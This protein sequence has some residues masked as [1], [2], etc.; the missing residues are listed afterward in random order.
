MEQDFSRR[1]QSVK[2]SRCAFTFALLA[3]F[4]SVLPVFAKTHRVPN[5]DP[6]AKL[7]IPD[8]WNVQ[9]VGESLQATTT[10]GGEHVM[11]VP[12]EGTK[13][14]ESLGEAI[15][16]VR[17]SGG[18]IIKADS[19]KQET[20]QVK[21]KQLPTVSWDGTAQDRP[22]K[23]RCYVIEGAEKK[24]LLLLFWGSPEAENKYRTQLKK[25]L[26]SVEPV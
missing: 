20:S 25:I 19:K 15:R 23:I 8:Q 4:A 3:I 13:V 18:I 10:D 16:Y 24:R 6:I 5:E 7:H 11:V 22:I 17:N 26:E 12:V 1:L 21:Q 14:A 9:E 2:Q